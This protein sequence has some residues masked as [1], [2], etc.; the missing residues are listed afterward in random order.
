MPTLADLEYTHLGTLGAT[1]TT[2]LDR[3]SQV[4]LPDPFA[5]WSGL[6]GFT[7]APS[8]SLTDHM[9]KAMQTAEGLTDVQAAALS[10]ADLRVLYWT[11]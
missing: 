11:P 10:T 4:Y 2:L 1:G 6:S 8:Y 9:R 5:Y 3:R 7:P